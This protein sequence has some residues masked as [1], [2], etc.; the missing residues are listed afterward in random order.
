MAAVPIAIGTSSV[1]ALG[2]LGGGALALAVPA[3]IYILLP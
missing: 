3:A 1:R 2:V